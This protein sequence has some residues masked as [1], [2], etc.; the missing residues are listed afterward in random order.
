MRPWLCSK[1][2]LSL[3]EKSLPALNHALL[4]WFYPQLFETF[5]ATMLGSMFAA[6]YLWL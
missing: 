4:A 2:R 5:F 1:L 6:K 3:H